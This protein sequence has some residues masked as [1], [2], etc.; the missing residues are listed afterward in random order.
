VQVNLAVMLLVAT[1][2]QTAYN[3]FQKTCKSS[4]VCNF[5]YNG[6]CSKLFFLG[7]NC[8]VYAFNSHNN[9]FKVGFKRSSIINLTENIKVLYA[10]VLDTR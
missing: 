2:S 9:C 7:L 6:C 10:V 1:K 4:M 3:D 8:F 5:W